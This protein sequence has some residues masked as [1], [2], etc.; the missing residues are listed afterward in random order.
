MEIIKDIKEFFL[1]LFF[2]N[3]ELKIINNEDVDRAEFIIKIFTFFLK[4]GVYEVGVK[5]WN[6]S[7]EDFKVRMFFENFITDGL[8]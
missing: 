5:I 1:R 8:D 7:I 4:N 6:W 3:D 2:I